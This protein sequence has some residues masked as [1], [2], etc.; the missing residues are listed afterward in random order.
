M[1]LFVIDASIAIKWVIDEDGTAAALEMR[2]HPLAAPDLLVAECA[3]ILWKKVHRGELNDREA[4]F[5]AQLLA[6]ADISLLPMRPYLEAATDIA[7]A[8]DHPAYDCIYIAAAEAERLP[9]VS[10]D[11]RL[12][13]KVR[14]DGSGR[15]S[16]RVISLAEATAKK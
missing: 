4:A 8:L 16:G 11:D 15:F 10:V 1:S 14:L 7:V 9:F 13:R 2:K 5:A 3:N 12:L 6:R